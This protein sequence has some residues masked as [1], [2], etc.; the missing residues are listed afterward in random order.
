MSDVKTRVLLVDDH[1]ILRQGLRSL[2]SAQPDFEIVGE[3][4]DGRSAVELAERLS[5]NV[6]VMDIGMPGLNGVD[7]TRQIVDRSP[8][9]RVVALSAWGDRRL[10]T[11]VLKAGASGYV[12][13][14]SAFEEL[15][16]AIR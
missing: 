5:P 1:H 7:A 9:V 2:L 11:Q 14:E 16:D 8:A 12:L 13:K 3:A 4:E 10:I 15:S 6:V